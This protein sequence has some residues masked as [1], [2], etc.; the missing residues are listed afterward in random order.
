MDKLEQQ[1]KRIEEM[2]I[3]VQRLKECLKRIK[4]LCNSARISL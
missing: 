3:E 1:Q 2:E 4:A